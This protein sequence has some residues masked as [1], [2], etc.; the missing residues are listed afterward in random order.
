MHTLSNATMEGEKI[1]LLFFVEIAPFLKKKLVHLQPIKFS[2]L[3]FG[4]YFK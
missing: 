1:D 3:P 4:A 2:L